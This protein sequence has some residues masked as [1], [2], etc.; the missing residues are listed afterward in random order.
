MFIKGLDIPQPSTD[1]D[2]YLLDNFLQKLPEV[3]TQLMDK[4]HEINMSIFKIME[5]NFSVP[6]LF[7]ER[8]SFLNEAKRKLTIRK[9]SNLE[10]LYSKLTENGLTEN[11]LIL[12]MKILDW[13]WEK[14]DS[15]LFSFKNV[16]NSNL[17]GHFINQLKSLLKSLLS[18]LGI[19]SDV[20]EEC[21]DLLS[22]ILEMRKH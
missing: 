7:K 6:D 5:I 18:A 13:F 14:T 20:Y 2:L 10:N 9:N 17:L 21:F 11:M 22:S 4:L 8:F 15:L 16:K 1:K 12:K 3:V 19:N